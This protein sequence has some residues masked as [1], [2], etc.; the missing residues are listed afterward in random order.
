MIS[1]QVLQTTIE[2]LKNI[3]RIELCVMDTEGK[4]LATTINHVEEYE[5]AV[6][7]F[8]DSPADSQVLQGHQF[9]KVFDEHQLEY[10]LLAK[11]DTDDV[12]MVGKLAAFQ[13]KN[14]LI[15]YKE[16]YD[17]DNFIKNLLLDNLLL[18]DIYN[19]AKKLHI[20]TAVKRVVFL[21]ETKHEK[22][23]GALETVKGLFAGKKNDFITQ[24]DEKNIILVKEIGNHETYADLDKTAKV[25][26]D[27]LNTEAMTKVHVAYGT[28]VQE[29]KDVSRSYKEAKMALD[30]G[31]IFYSDRNVIAYSSL[32][33]GRLIYQLPMPLCKM[34]ISEIFGDKSPDNFDDETIATINKFFENSLN[35]SETSRQLYIHRNTLVYRLDKLQKSTGLDLR[36]F[37]DAITFKIA[38]MVVK[39]MKYMENF[40]Y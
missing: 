31:K 33:I 28:I 8:V 22:D 34:F 18:V 1:N 5:E 4:A 25:I 2:G 24:V 7:A 23:V 29:L 12:Y 19:R 32:G 14:L 38:L 21:I 10:V 9:F 40:E 17:K 13:I 35:V 20:E 11:G 3:T 15:A 39:Y 36:V 6:L 37:D 26:L 30:V 16:R 27:M